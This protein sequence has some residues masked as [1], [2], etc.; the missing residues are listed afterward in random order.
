MDQPLDQRR[1]RGNIWLD[2]MPAWSEFDWL[3]KSI[4]VGTAEFNITEPIERCMATTVDPNTGVSDA[5]TLGTLNKEY[6]HQ[7]FG[8]FGIVSKSGVVNIGD[9]AELI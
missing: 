1:F 6:G 7:N 9:N 5:D 4:R 2:D 3:G 8:V